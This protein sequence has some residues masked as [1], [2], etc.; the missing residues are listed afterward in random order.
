MRPTNLEIRWCQGQLLSRRCRNTVP[1]LC[2]DSTFHRKRHNHSSSKFHRRRHHQCSSP[3]AWT[4]LRQHMNTMHIQCNVCSQYHRPHRAQHQ[5]HQ[6]DDV[7][8][9][10]DCLC[11]SPRLHCRHRYNRLQ[12][13]HDRLLPHRLYRL[14]RLHRQHQHQ[15]R[16]P[17]RCLHCQQRRQCAPLYRQCSC[18]R[19]RRPVVRRT[20][21]A[22]SGTCVC[23]AATFTTITLSAQPPLSYVPTATATTYLAS[24]RPARGVLSSSPPSPQERPAAPPPAQLPA[25]SSHLSRLCSMGPPQPPQRPP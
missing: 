20:S 12:G 9:L 2:W 22:L 13:R 5:R 17:N 8:R 24:A 19:H 10:C 7:D 15:H 21:A 4:F 14:H 18:Q 1:L 23:A 16:Q 6:P 11:D 25:P 3:F